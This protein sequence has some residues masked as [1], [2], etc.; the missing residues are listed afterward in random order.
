M[1]VRWQK[2]K[3]RDGVTRLNAI[4]CESRRVDG[5]PRQEHIAYLGAIDDVWLE[6]PLD[7][8]AANLKRHEFWEKAEKRLAPLANRLGTDD[9]K[10]REQLSAKVPMANTDEAYKEYLRQRRVTSQIKRLVLTVDG[11]G[12]G[13][14]KVRIEDRQHKVNVRAG[15]AV[16]DDALDDRVQEILGVEG[17]DYNYRPVENFDEMFDKE[18][19][20]AVVQDFSERM[21]KD[22]DAKPSNH[23]S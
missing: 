5:K 1:F 11:G 3:R 17:E 21:A 19:V 7:D 12:V 22:S 4:L 13:L 14:A 15:V 8:P 23:C 6:Q 18:E 9:H 2:R 16:R 20:E 10:I